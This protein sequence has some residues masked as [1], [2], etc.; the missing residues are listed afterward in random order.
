MNFDTMPEL[1]WAAGYPFAI[2]LMAVVCIS[3]YVIF[4]K[5]QHR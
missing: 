5:H 2:I 1:K 3:L 4:K